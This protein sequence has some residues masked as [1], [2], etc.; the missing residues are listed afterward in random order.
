MKSESHNQLK[1]VTARLQFS[2]V[3]KNT[4]AINTMQLQLQA[5][6]LILS[7]LVSL[8]NQ[9]RIAQKKEISIHS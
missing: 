1:V 9:L 2:T 3:S 4:V 7:V 8:M 6:F 5:R